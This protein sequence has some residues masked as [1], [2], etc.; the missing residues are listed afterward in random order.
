MSHIPDRSRSRSP[1]RG[2]RSPTTPPGPPPSTRLADRE[3]T[4][5]YVLHIK[6]PNTGHIQHVLRQLG[7]DIIAKATLL[8]FDAK[9]NDVTTRLPHRVT[10]GELLGGH[11]V[12]L[13]PTRY[14][15]C[16]HTN[17][18]CVKFD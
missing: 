2:Q 6:A 8:E 15:E 14:S 1:H 11:V 3:N 13:E 16:I 12:Q 5:Q 17:L 18:I 10:N 4:I 9:A 7:A